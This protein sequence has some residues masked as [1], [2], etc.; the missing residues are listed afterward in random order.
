LNSLASRFSVVI[1]PDE[2]PTEDGSAC[3]YVSMASRAGVM[4]AMREQI[5]AL[6]D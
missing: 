5:T 6:G 1:A 3:A 4:A 2:V